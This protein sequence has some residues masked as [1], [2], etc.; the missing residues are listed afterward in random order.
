MPEWI[1]VYCDQCSNTTKATRSQRVWCVRYPHHLRR[2]AR[3]MTPKEARSFAV[4]E[5][6]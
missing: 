4:D 5:T 3:P 1:T 6:G 2:Q